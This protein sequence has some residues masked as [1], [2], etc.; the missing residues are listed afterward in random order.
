MSLSKSSNTAFPFPFF[1]LP[2]A[3]DQRY[4][5][6]ACGL[7]LLLLPVLICSGSHH[8]GHRKT[9]GAPQT[10][11]PGGFASFHQGATCCFSTSAITTLE[12]AAAALHVVS[13]YTA[14]ASV[15]GEAAGAAT[16]T[17]SPSCSL[18]GISSALPRIPSDFI[19]ERVKRAKS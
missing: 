17:R 16:A 12:V 4:C 11:M 8:L 18:G 10:K 5:G 14:R 13:R 15:R 19:E 6:R 9:G 7:T 3:N 1:F 2:T